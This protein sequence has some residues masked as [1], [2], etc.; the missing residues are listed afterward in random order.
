MAV[1]NLCGVEYVSFSELARDSGMSPQSLQRAAGRAGLP[2]K[3]FGRSHFVQRV[4]FEKWIKDNPKKET[5]N[6]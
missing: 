5:N 4:A 2:M 6:E 3:K 1:V